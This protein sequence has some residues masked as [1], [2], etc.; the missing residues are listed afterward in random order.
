MSQHFPRAH[1]LA[2][3]ELPQLQE[4][5]PVAGNQ[6]IRLSGL[7]EG[8]QSEAPTA[9]GDEQARRGGISSSL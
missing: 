8:K 9:P 2:R 5:A 7:G 1:D 4:I 6:E 3:P